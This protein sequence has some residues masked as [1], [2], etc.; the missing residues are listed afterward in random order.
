MINLKVINEDNF[1]YAFQ[2]RLAYDDRCFQ[3]GK[4]VWK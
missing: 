4:R 2:L 3:T 1:L